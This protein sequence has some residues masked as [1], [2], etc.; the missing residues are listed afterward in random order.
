MPSTQLRRTPR[1]AAP[2]LAG[3]IL[4]AIVF[5]VFAAA[6]AVKSQ[7]GYYRVSVG[8]FEVTA[9]SDGWLNLEPTKLLQGRSGERITQDLTAAHITEPV[10]TSMNAFLVN[11]GTKL[12]L[13]DTGGAGNMGTDGGKLMQSLRNAGYTPA[14]ID[15]IYITHMH[16]DH[17]G[18]LSTEG[19]PN[20]PN[21]IV[22]ADKADASFWLGEAA[23]AA[24]A[25]GSKPSFRMAQDELDPY[26]K[27]GRFKP[28]DGNT[29][30]TPGIRSV[31]R[32]GHTPGHNGYLIESGQQKLE[33]IGDLIHV[34]AVQFPHPEVVIRFDSDSA[35]ASI[36]RRKAF[37][38]AAKDGR[39]IAAAHLSFPGIGYINAEGAGYRWVPVNYAP[40]R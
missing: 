24:A 16:G 30:L 39:L 23:L 13:I 7:A 36:D 29:E 28:F 3:A 34:G 15:E 26:V 33:V 20:F 19:K 37:D 6:P 11:T 14:Q 4:A 5:P 9:L 10:A 25:E 18:N 1:P 27:A 8:A 21:A 2:L 31:A 32:H 17:V 12:V 40:V 22:R 35:A 38:A